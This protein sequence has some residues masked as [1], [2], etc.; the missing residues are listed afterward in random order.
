MKKTV[1]TLLAISAMSTLL[2]LTACS[3]ENPL[4]TQP[5]EDSVQFISA[6]S[7][8]AA[9]K[10]E[11]NGPDGNAAYR[12]CFTSSVRNKSYCPDLFKQMVIYAKASKGKFS[13]VTVEDLQNQSFVDS[14]KKTGYWF[15]VVP[16]E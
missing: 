11:Y 14:L 4:V 9:K 6:A 7:S 8:Y 15:N 3:H 5:L 12:F 16:Y 13:S 2:G 10:V 1:K